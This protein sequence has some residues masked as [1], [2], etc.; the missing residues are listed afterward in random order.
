MALAV[1]KK[2]LFV[3]CVL[4]IALQRA[5]SSVLTSWG[6]LRTSVAEM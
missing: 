6:A 4:S 5:A 1:I 3:V 2:D